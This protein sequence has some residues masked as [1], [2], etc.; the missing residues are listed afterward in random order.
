M[1]STSSKRRV[2]VGAFAIE[3]NSFAP[4]ST[5]VADFAEQVWAV[6]DEV[7]HDV[8]GR[9]SELHAAWEVLA[10]N[11]FD[12]V[13]SLAAWSAPR[14]PLEP[15]TLDA[16]VSHILARCDDTL[17]GAYLMLHG[18]A[19]AHGEDDPEGTLLSALR[20]RLRPDLPIA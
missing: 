12:V 2:L 14:Q 3:A 7:T 1:S 4:G 6:G 16:I 10:A 20:E 15:E 19:V 13:P 5:T 17:A 9:H 11:G 18:A 8:L